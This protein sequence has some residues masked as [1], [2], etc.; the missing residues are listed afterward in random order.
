VNKKQQHKEKGVSHQAQ[1]NRNETTV[2]GKQE[3][4]YIDHTEKTD[5]ATASPRELKEPTRSFGK[6]ARLNSSPVIAIFTVLLAIIG[7]LQYA[8]YRKQLRYMQVDQRAWVK[9]V[10]DVNP[11]IAEGEPIKA[12][13]TV[14]NIGKTSAGKVYSEVVLRVVE[15][16]SHPE[17]KYDAFFRFSTHVLFPNDPAIFPATSMEN[18]PEHA[19]RQSVLSKQAYADLT[20]GRAYIVAYSKTTYA[21][22]FGVDHYLTTC[23]WRAFVDGQYAAADCTEYNNMDIS[24]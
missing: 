9:L 5:K 13:V 2:F 6:W 1:D 15:N 23:A 17:F 12:T 20:S 16:G 11:N 24:Q 7:V 21:D 10:P 3:G 8:V 19:L 22:I 18:S 4:T 14:T